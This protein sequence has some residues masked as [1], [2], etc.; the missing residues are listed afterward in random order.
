M[1]NVFLLLS[2]GLFLLSCGG[3]QTVTTDEDISPSIEAK[4]CDAKDLESAAE[5]LC[6]FYDKQDNSSHLTDEEYDKLRDELEVFNNEIDDVIAA[7]I[8]SE[9]D[10]S[11]AIDKKCP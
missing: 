10:L 9:L 8:Y 6:V 4:S 3:D 2:L 11:E 1:K 5:C 7:G